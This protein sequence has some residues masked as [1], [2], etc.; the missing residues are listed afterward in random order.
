MAC[1]RY[2]ESADIL[3]TSNKY[4]DCYNNAIR[5]TDYFIGEV[6]KRLQSSASSILYFQITG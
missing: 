4:E 1:D 3:D 2:P 6:A 5:F